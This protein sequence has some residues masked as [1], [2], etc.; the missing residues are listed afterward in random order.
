[1]WKKTYIKEF[2]GINKQD[3]WQMWADVNH[4]AEWHDDLD[5]CQ[6]EGEFKAGNHFYLTPKGMKPI[7]IAI[8]D[9][10]EGESFTDCTPFFGAKLYDKHVVEEIPGGVRIH[11]ELFVTGPL[12]WLW[13]MLV[14]KD[15]AKGIEPDTQALVERIRKKD[16]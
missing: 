7:K 13:V 2:F 1:M 5:A 15:V 16:V 6:I 8:I 10:T 11:N 14:A 3:V 4:W 9:M 12:A